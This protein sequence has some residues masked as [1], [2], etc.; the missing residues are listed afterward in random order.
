MAESVG[1]LWVSREVRRIDPVSGK[2]STVTDREPIPGEHEP[3]P[4]V[5]IRESPEFGSATFRTRLCLR[6]GGFFLMG[7]PEKDPAN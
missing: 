2:V 4:V 1:L 7:P 5:D 3:G 6:C